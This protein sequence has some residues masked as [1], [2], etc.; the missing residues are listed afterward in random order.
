MFSLKCAKF[1]DI[2]VCTYDSDEE[3]KTEFFLATVYL[4]W[5]AAIW[6]LPEGSY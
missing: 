6:L 4:E 1:V 2:Y 3:D 5:D